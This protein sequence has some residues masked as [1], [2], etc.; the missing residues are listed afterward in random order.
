MHVNI[1]RM[2]ILEISVCGRTFQTSG[3]SC[4]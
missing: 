4:N 1:E 2:C 3:F